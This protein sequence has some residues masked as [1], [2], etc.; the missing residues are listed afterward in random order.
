MIATMPR[1]RAKSAHRRAVRAAE[2]SRW[3]VL[4]DFTDGNGGLG[5][6]IRRETAASAL[7]ALTQAYGHAGREFQAYIP[8]LRGLEGEALFDEAFERLCHI[9]TFPGWLEP[10]PLTID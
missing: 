10:A 3:T 9:A 4:L 5:P 2:R 1:I 6:V 7:E 8:E